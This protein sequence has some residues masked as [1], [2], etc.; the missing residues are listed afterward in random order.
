MFAKV[1]DYKQG[2]LS[3]DKIL[4]SFQGW[5]AYA[6]WANSLGVRREVVKRI[7]APS[8]R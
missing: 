1:E 7:Y 4:K 2:K 8:T 5:N 6:K 3:K